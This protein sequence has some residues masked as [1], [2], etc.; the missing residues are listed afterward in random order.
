VSD[1]LWKALHHIYVRRD[2]SLQKVQRD[3]LPVELVQLEGSK[4]VVRYMYVP[5]FKTIRR[6]LY[7]VPLA[8]NTP[9]NIIYRT[10]QISR[11]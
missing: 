7:D 2:T 1:G 8:F 3:T 9:K 4:R 11:S 5:V 10:S 6:Y